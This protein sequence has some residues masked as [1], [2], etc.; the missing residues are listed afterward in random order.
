MSRRI[1]N[2]VGDN[3]IFIS[4]LKLAEVE[5]KSIPLKI[6]DQRKK[7]TGG[8]LHRHGLISDRNI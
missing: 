3:K 7:D 1:R 2:E 4:C 6:A 8:K 5:D